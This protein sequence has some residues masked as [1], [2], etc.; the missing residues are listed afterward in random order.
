[1]QQSIQAQSD[2]LAQGTR[3]P[4]APR[5]RPARA[6]DLDRQGQQLYREKRYDE[7]LKKFQAAMEIKPGDAVLLNNLGFIYYVM[8]RY[9]DALT[10]LQ[11]TL[12][13]DPRRKEAHENIADAYMKLG[14]GAEAKQ[15]YQQ[16]LALNPATSRG[17][18]VRNIL[19]G[20]N[21]TPVNKAQLP[22]PLHHHD[23]ALALI[24]L[25]VQQAAA[26]R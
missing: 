8:G 25:R 18:E 10:Y 3:T 9:D 26:V 17:E 15:H 1:L 24:V 4:T 23:V 19:Q 16:F 13:V 2:K 12:A 11:K 20:L 7:A 6:Y 21:L 22:K 5:S 14:R